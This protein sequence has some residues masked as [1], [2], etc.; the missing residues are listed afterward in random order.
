[1]VLHGHRQ[2]VVRLKG[3][4]VA[5]PWQAGRDEQHR[6]QIL[7]G[8]GHAA[9][10]RAVD[11]YECVALLGVHHLGRAIPKIVH[12]GLVET[13]PRS[14]SVQLFIQ[15]YQRNEHRDRVG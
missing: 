11:E 8:A 5:E 15:V 13:G 9:V 7:R 12:T 1:M 14:R 3:Q 6:A 4:R 10:I 2:R